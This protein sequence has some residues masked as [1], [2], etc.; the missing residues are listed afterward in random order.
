MNRDPQ[1][2][3][4]RLRRGV[5]LLPSL[6]TF[7]NLLLGF[8]AIVRALRGEFE[9]ATVLIFVA[10][11]LDALDGRIARLTR[12]E[13]AF[14]RE[15]DSLADILTFGLA[16]ALLAHLWGLD[17]LGRPGWLV[18]L[19]FL[20]CAATRLARFNVKSAAGDARYFV[21]LPSPAAAAALLSI[22]YFLPARSGERWA[23]ALML[24]ALIV[25]GSLMVST[26]RYLSFKHFDLSRRWSYRAA[27]LLGVVLLLVSYNPPA[28]LFSIAV[29]YALSGPLAW[30]VGRLFRLRA[31]SEE[32]PAEESVQT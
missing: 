24:A 6:F 7:G 21:G 9:S 22:V 5:Y 28:I 25:T 32:T 3:G 2:R 12:T 8:Y 29:A 18:P 20:L 14:G 30:I 15:F 26:F 31:R 1:N 11:I 13:S 4:R 27:T 19:F 17:R 23:Q 16:P 10:G